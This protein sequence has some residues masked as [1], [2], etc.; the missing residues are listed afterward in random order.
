MQINLQLVA[1]ASWPNVIKTKIAAMQMIY[2]VVE[3]VL[4]SCSREQS[5]EKNGGGDNGQ[6]DG[7][8]R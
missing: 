5:D 2:S 1:N 8:T 6:W 3:V 7:K 4:L